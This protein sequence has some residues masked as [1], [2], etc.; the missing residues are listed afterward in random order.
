LEVLNALS[1][2]DFIRIE[3]ELLERGHL[4]YFEAYSKIPQTIEALH[5]YV[6]IRGTLHEKL[7]R[8]KDYQKIVDS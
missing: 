7:A 2:E 5:G 6:R 1:L 3:E 8:I 4:K